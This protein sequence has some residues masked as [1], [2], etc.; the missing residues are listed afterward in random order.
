[1][2][3]LYVAAHLAEAHLLR[4]LLAAAR[5]EAHVFNEYAVG[6]IGELPPGAVS[7]EVW[8]ADERDRAL[9]QA[10]VAEYEQGAGVEGSCRC[11]TCGED[12]PAGFAVCW[13]CSQPL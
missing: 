2:Q 5:I 11:L 9:A 1:M 12:S 10:V 8:I 13:H 6:A 7:P 3:R 4:A